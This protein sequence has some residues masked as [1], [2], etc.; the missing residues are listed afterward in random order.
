MD[1]SSLLGGGSGGGGGAPG[2]SSSATSG[3]NFGAPAQP[4]LIP[5]MLAALVLVVLI[6]TRK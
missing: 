1:L 3:V 4:W 6:L 5:A 2:L